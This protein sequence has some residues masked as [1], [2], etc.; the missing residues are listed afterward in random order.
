MKTSDFDIYSDEN[1]S[2]FAKN[3][4]MNLKNNTLYLFFFL[5]AIKKEIVKPARGLSKQKATTSLNQL[6]EVSKD[7]FLDY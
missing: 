5:G 1:I 4:W 3:E 6:T 2:I 7:Y